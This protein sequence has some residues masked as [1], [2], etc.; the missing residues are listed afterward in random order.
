MMK[1]KTNK[2]DDELFSYAYYN[3]LDLVFDLSI[4]HNYRIALHPRDDKIDIDRL[5]NNLIKD[6]QWLLYPDESNN[7]T[8]KTGK[9]VD[10]TI[11]LAILAEDY[12]L[13]E[14]FKQKFT[15]GIL[16]SIFSDVI[17]PSNEKNDEIVKSHY[18]YLL[19]L[20]INSMLIKKF[21]FVEFL[22]DYLIQNSY[23]YGN[24]RFFYIFYSIYLFTI[25]S[26]NY[27]H[28]DIKAYVDKMP[29][30]ENGTWFRHLRDN[31]RTL[32]IDE[33]INLP[34]YLVEIYD[35]YSGRLWCVPFHDQMYT[36]SDYEMSHSLLF[37]V[38]FEII[39][40][41]SVFNTLDYSTIS[42]KVNNMLKQLEK[43]NKEAYDILLHCLIELAKEK[44]D[45]DENDS[46]LDFIWQRKVDLKEMFDCPVGKALFEYALARNKE[47]LDNNGNHHVNE[48]DVLDFFLQISKSA[49]LSL[50]LSEFSDLHYYEFSRCFL[51]DTETI[52]FSNSFYTKFIKD[53]ISNN[54]ARMIE[55]RTKNKFDKA[56]L[57][58]SNNLIFTTA[59]KYELLDQGIP[60]QILLRLNMEKKKHYLSNA[61]IAYCE[62]AL[63]FGVSLKTGSIRVCDLSESE[64]NSFIDS[65]Y[66]T[67]SGIYKYYDYEGS[68]VFAYYSY[69]EVYKKVK[70]RYKKVTLMFYISFNKFIDELVFK[71]GDIED[72][73][74]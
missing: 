47:K 28:K 52:E 38:W 17:K 72:G 19:T 66:K 31:F 59:S 71:V 6:I 8:N 13:E 56:M 25:K 67:S 16:R 48:T 34:L 22:D 4:T 24:I 7:F 54:I 15:R 36:V 53:N 5:I 10:L 69:E 39:R 61:K 46:Y 2:S 44:L 50:G 1:S 41:Y 73:N 49:F 60:Y 30:K 14:R 63:D 37:K 3:A 57:E 62:G 11:A 51:F 40:Y 23:L 27:I 58:K 64:I 26:V 70:D 29:Q 65:N 21:A 33:V 20:I 45:S 12:K 68:D 18:D 55:A 43:K 74:Y 9:N 42:T 32:T 35:S